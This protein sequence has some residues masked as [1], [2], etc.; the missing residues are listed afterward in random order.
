MPRMAQIPFPGWC[1]PQATSVGRQRKWHLILPPGQRPACNHEV[2]ETKGKDG[3]KVPGKVGAYTV[4]LVAD[5]NWQH[6]WHQ[7]HQPSLLPATPWILMELVLLF[8]SHGCVR[9]GEAPV[10]QHPTPKFRFWPWHQVLK[11]QY[12]CGLGMGGE[13]GGR[14]IWN[15]IIFWVTH[16]THVFQC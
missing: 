13:G 1:L 4:V 16:S 7:C 14:W 12:Q 3:G 15:T 10:C 6:V 8:L 11:R 2:W 5:E 9:V